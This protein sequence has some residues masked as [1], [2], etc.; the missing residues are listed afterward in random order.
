MNREDV[1]EDQEIKAQAERVH[2][3]LLALPRKRVSRWK[4]PLQFRKSGRS[5]VQQTTEKENANRAKAVGVYWRLP[6]P[7]IYA[8]VRTAA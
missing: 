5:R 7:G 1:L 2:Y 4:S 8:E 3:R 6:E